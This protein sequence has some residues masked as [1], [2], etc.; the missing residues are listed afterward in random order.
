MHVPKG[1]CDSSAFLTVATNVA[2]SGN[3]SCPR[4]N[5]NSHLASPVVRSAGKLS[6][7]SKQPDLPHKIHS[8]AFSLMDESQ[9][10]RWSEAGP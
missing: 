6:N 4:Q 3:W 1:L 5:G 2:A 9:L 8:S 10:F 7:L